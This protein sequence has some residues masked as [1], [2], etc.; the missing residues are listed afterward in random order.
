[1]NSLE[2]QSKTSAE[3]V[4]EV[5]FFVEDFKND[6]NNK[7]QKSFSAL[8]KET[9]SAESRLAILENSLKTNEELL[10]K[11]LE[12]FSSKF[13]SAS[14]KLSMR[15]QI[16][17]NNLNALDKNIQETNGRINSLRID[18]EKIVARIEALEKFSKDI[19]LVKEN[20]TNNLVY[21]LIIGIITMLISVLVNVWMSKVFF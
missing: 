21:P 1:M 5:K 13:D 8:A 12:I 18:L 6:L 14:E 7:F 15:T 20:R 3:I 9:S 16:N 4:Q 17:E 11:D 10:K 19:A 2:Q